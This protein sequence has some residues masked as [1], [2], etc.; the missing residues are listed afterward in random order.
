M[1]S[2]NSFIN[3]YVINGREVRDYIA[4]EYYG[5]NNYHLI[6]GDENNNRPD[7]ISKEAFESL[8]KDKN[9]DILLTAS[10]LNEVLSSQ[11]RRPE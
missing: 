10:E 8:V 6:G 2:I 7:V 3:V 1:R 9:L 11:I 5:V 4:Y